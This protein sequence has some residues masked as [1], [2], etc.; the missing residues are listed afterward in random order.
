MKN[1]T[2]QLHSRDEKTFF[3][4]QI[5]EE[6]E[7]KKEEKSLYLFS[8]NILDDNDFDIFF[9]KIVSQVPQKITIS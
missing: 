3:L 6:L 4:T 7:I 2:L 9:Q 5:I 1:L 8:M